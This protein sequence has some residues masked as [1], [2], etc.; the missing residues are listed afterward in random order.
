M[1]TIQQAYY[2]MCEAEG[3]MDAGTHYMLVLALNQ[4][5]I[6]SIGKQEARKIAAEL[7]A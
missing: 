5:G 4:A 2:A 6:S 1:A 7:C 3:A